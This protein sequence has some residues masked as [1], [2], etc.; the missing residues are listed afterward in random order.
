M[1]IHQN[2][3]I[4]TSSVAKRKRTSSSKFSALFTSEIDS[5]KTSPETPLEQT[6]QEVATPT[7]QRAVFKQATELLDQALEQW[8]IDGTLTEN[9]ITSI[10]QARQQLSLLSSQDPTLAQAETILA[11]ESKRL[12]L[13]NH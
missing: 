7:Q 11:V 4:N 1:K 9:T 10:Q 3:N 13:L 12:K 6:S 5:G 2:N 8:E